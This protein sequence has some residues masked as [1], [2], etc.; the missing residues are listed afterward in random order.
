M[1][2]IRI[3]MF[4]YDS[5]LSTEWTTG[6]EGRVLPLWRGNALRLNLDESESPVQSIVINT[7][8]LHQAIKI[9]ANNKAPFHFKEIK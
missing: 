6:I 3:F 7:E 4:S 1:A 2:S 9:S 5:L 8:C